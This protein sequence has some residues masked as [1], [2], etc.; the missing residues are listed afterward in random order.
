[1]LRKVDRSKIEGIYKVFRLLTKDR[2]QYVLLMTNGG[3]MCSCLLLQNAGIVCRHFFLLMRQSPKCM[4][5]ISL[6][7]RRWF[8]EQHH[9]LKDSD[10]KG[11]PFLFCATHDADVLSQAPS[12]R[13]MDFIHDVFP[14]R[15]QAPA[16][17]KTEA[18][19]SWRL[20]N[21]SGAAKTIADIVAGD[22]EAYNLVNRELNNILLKL[23]A[24]SSGSEPIENPMETN[25][26]GR[27]RTKRVQGEY[28]KNVKRQRKS[29]KSK[30]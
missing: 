29:R 10:L 24:K 21:I 5:H 15:P 30:K 11:R 7:P 8:Q 18:T 20:S 26:K 25:L 12:E 16:L 2:P 17:S 9:G 22:Q 4:Y 28:E 13:Y 14:S 3:Y 1:M 27:P 19:R 23:R 6:I